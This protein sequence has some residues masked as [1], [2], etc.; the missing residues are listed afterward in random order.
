MT[1]SLG[2][3]MDCRCVGEY[4]DEAEMPAKGAHHRGEVVRPRAVT[5]YFEVWSPEATAR[6]FTVLLRDNRTVVVRGHALKYIPSAAN[7]G[8]FGSY[9]VIS[10]LGSDEVT[11]ALFPVAGVTGIFRGELRPSRESA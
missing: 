9:A 4:V 5:R 3:N 11:V 2:A 10:R 7:P 6:E 8:D 1:Y